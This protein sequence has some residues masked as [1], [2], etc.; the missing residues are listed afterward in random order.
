MNRGFETPQA[1]QGTTTPAYPPPRPA[2]RIKTPFKH[3]AKRSQQR[4]INLGQLRTSNL[5]LQH[6]QLMAEQENLDLLL[7]L[8]AT[9]EHE[10][11]KD[12]PQRPVEQRN[13]DALG[14]TRHD[15]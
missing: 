15:R 1:V 11:L 3:T 5:T 2:N 10:Q 8:G 4:P 12:S 13:R 6:P 14:P 9:P 7:P